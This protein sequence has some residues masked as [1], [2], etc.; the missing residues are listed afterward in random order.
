MYLARGV[1]RPPRWEYRR[2]SDTAKRTAFDVK[3]NKDQHKA[4]TTRLV[5]EIRAA[6]RARAAVIHDHGLID[7][8][9]SLYEQQSQKGIS[10]D[11]PRYGGADLASPIGTENVDT[12]SA[13]AAQTIFKLE[14]LWIVEGVGASAQKAPIVEEF[15]QWRQETIRLQKV[16]KRAITGALVEPGSILEVCEDAEPYQKHETIKAQLATDETGA[17]LL[18]GKTGQPMPA[19]NEQGDPIPVEGEPQDGAFVEVKRVHTDYKRRGGYVRRRSM[20][21][22]VF[23]PS[24]ADD[25]REVWGHAHR[26]WSPLVD[27]TAKM[28]NDEY[29]EDAVQLLGGD[30]QERQQ[31][32]EHDRSGTTV[33][34]VQGYDLTEKELWRVQLWAN[35]ND[36]GLCFY[37]AVVSEQHECVL[38]L[39]YDW[40]QRF[41]TVYVNP[42]PCPYSV[43]GYSLIL[44]KL[45]PTIEE[46]AVWRNMNADRDTLDANKPLGR[47]HGAQ[48][49]PNIQPFGIGQVIDMGSKGEVFAIEGFEG[50]SQQ[51]LAKEAQCVTD[52]QRIVG[53]NDIA[54][55]QITTKNRTLGENEMA[56]RQ[57]FVRTDDP[58]SNIQEALE[59]VGE[60][61]HAIEVQ[62]LKEMGHGIE[63][64]GSVMENINL[65]VTDSSFEGTFTADM[66][67]GTFRFKPRGSSEETDP[68]R[69][70]QRRDTG[71]QKLLGLAKVNQF[72]AQR[73]GSPAFADAMMQDIVDEMKPRNKAAFLQPLPPPMPMGQPGAPGMPPGIPSPAGMPMGGAAP[74]FGGEQL[75]QQLLSEAGGTPQ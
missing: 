28:E 32:P 11:T 36:K 39:K 30:T 69:R 62:T 21:D 53:T 37:T 57:S 13:R 40:L 42:Y 41:R 47:L 65:R 15:M 72:I 75:V 54:L 49:D 44:T 6:I 64:P 31:A 43:Y 71:V 34:T 29:D 24:H 59:E 27:I 17:V 60:L 3:L 45:L 16:V 4:I 18:D 68:Q 25:E 20:K 23:L 5:E 52:G 35:L 8:A 74:S 61:L 10:R 14:P 38:S 33:E 48:W 67:A 26:F 51:A 22:F 63:A 1:A 58:I 55:G 70:A 50:S 66:L 9:Y 73:I 19:R 7:F 2:V 56:T 12:L 46:H